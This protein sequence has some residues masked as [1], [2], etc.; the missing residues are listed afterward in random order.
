LSKHQ[1]YRFIG[2][3]NNLVLLAGVNMYFPNNFTPVMANK[4]QKLQARANKELQI[5]YG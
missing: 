4:A 3:I 1:G 5:F 2:S